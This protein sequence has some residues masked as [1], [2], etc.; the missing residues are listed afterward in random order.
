MVIGMRRVCVVSLL[1]RVSRWRSQRI[2]CLSFPPIKRPVAMSKFRIT[3][4][5]VTVG[6]SL[7][8]IAGCGVDLDP[9]LVGPLREVSFSNN[10][11]AADA[12]EFAPDSKSLNPV[13]SAPYPQRAN[14]FAYPG[15]S[16]EAVET[17][18]TDTSLTSS[19][20]V[21]GFAN[22]DGPVVMLKFRDQTHTMS[23][24]DKH[25]SIQV[26]EIAPPRVTLKMANLIW[27]I[28]MF[29]KSSSK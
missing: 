17:T 6:L 16:V 28:S 3:R 1:D 12:T 8:I 13:W 5:A 23:V 11:V 27:T 21:V 26:T 19:V 20:S 29:D 15:D 9:S 24:G 4:T 10:D 14:A 22:V 2:R 18:K 7:V 25:G